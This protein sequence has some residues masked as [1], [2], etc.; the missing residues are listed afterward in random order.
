R[1][2]GRRRHRRGRIPRAPGSRRDVPDRGCGSA[3]DGAAPAARRLGGRGHAALARSALVNLARSLRAADRYWLTRFVLLRLLGFVYAVAFLAAAPQLVP[4]I[5]S[6]GLLPVSPFLDDVG[7]RLGSRWDGFWALP[8]LFW[9]DASDA[10]L[11]AVAWTG[12]ALAC[13]VVAGFANSLL[14]AAL[15]ALYMSIVHVGQDWYGYGWEIQ[16]LETGFL[17]IF[18]VPLLDARPFPRRPPPI[19]VIALFRWLALPIMLR[20][21]LVKN[22]RA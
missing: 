7:R 22:T 6:D 17:A 3:D 19:A 12:T 18:L 20:A 10:T 4:L 15:W 13:A 14:L 2:C 9:I 8:S 1:V 21:G 5:G 11:R 16:L